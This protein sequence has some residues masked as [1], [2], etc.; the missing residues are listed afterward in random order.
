MPETGKLQLAPHETLQLHELLG[1]KVALVKKLKASQAMV[2]NPDLAN[3]IED[4]LNT[5]KLEIKELQQFLEGK[6]LQ[7]T[8]Q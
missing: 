6:G 2:Q 1:S 8:L 7:G 5:K 4:S 3:L